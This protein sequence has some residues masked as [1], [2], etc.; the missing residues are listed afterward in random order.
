MEETGE[1]TSL[2][3]DI[4]SSEV[5]SPSISP[6]NKRLTGSTSGCG[7]LNSRPLCDGS[8]NINTAHG[9]IPVGTTSS[10]R[11]CGPPGG[12]GGSGVMGPAT[13]P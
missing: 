1:E 3:S 8:A 10:S 13:R 5:D 6:S 7:G 4:V 9:A 12:G 2:S 11:I